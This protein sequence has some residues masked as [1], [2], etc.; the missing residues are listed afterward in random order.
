[1]LVYF[2]KLPKTVGAVRHKVM[3]PTEEDLNSIYKNL[4]NFQVRGRG[5][6]FFGSAKSIRRCTI[7]GKS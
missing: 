2:R 7:H 3:T 6:S 5:S 4:Q 1:M